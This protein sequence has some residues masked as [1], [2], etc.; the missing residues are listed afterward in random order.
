MPT[1]TS[2]NRS[3]L[4]QL[5]RLPPD[6]QNTLIAVFTSQ[7]NHAHNVIADHEAD[8]S[9]DVNLL[10]ITI[11][12]F[13]QTLTAFERDI[14]NAVQTAV[15][16][17]N[18]Q[19]NEPAVINYSFEQP[20]KSS[21]D[22]DGDSLQS[23]HVI[24]VVQTKNYSFDKASPSS[25][26]LPSSHNLAISI[27][28]RSPRRLNQRSP[29]RLQPVKEQTW[30]HTYQVTDESSGQPISASI[31]PPI[32]PP[33]ELPSGSPAVL[34]AICSAQ[35]SNRSRKYMTAPHDL[36]S[37]MAEWQATHTKAATNLS[38]R[39]LN[40]TASPACSSS[41]S[42]IS[43]NGLSSKSTFDRARSMSQQISSDDSD[44]SDTDSDDEPSVPEKSKRSSLVNGASTP[45]NNPHNMFVRGAATMRHEEVRLM[46]NWMR[47]ANKQNGEPKPS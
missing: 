38:S 17:A 18:K 32:V 8:L 13:K 43:S 34:D 33:I 16:Q 3:M 12:S 2:P 19:T 15:K 27:A 23:A 29:M 28:S 25:S 1:T 9:N 20:T 37:M 39:V 26:N 35:M 21:V 4:L 41:P 6:L 45:V 44:D 11:A 10:S 46:M 47:E 31:K 22:A 42:A 24:D 40:E 5:A 36:A 30:D 7:L 14:H